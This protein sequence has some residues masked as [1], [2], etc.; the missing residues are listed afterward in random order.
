MAG[1]NNFITIGPIQGMI[2]N[3]SVS[4]PKILF[5]VSDETLPPQPSAV[6]SYVGKKFCVMADRNS[7]LQK[8]IP[9]L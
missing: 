9:V 7:D 2:A 3:F 5:R 4:G 6:S 8:K 1:V